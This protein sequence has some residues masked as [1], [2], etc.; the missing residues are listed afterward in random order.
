MMLSTV[1]STRPEAA[2]FAA[3]DA[4]GFVCA[5]GEEIDRAAKKA[6]ARPILNRFIDV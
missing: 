6:A 3:A 1:I 4:G 2:G 5:D